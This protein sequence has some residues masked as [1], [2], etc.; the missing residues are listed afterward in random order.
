MKLDEKTR[1]RKGCK[2]SIEIYD[3]ELMH[4]RGSLK[5]STLEL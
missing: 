5:L 1:R 2:R 4:E 3:V